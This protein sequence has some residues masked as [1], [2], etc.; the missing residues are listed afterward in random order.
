MSGHSKW[1]KIKRQKG[2]KD[3]KR[4]ALFTKLAKNI[5]LAASE[6]GGDIDMNFSLRLAVE[7]AKQANMPSDN[8]ARAI[9]KGTGEGEKMDIQRISYEA[10]G[11]GGSALIIDC[12]TDNTNR[13]I[14]EVRKTVENAGAKITSVGS[15]GWK[16][17]E[18]GLITIRP[19][20]IVKS[21]KFGAADS[22]EKVDQEEAE[23]EL[24]EIDGISDIAESEMENEEGEVTNVLEI[25]TEKSD[26]ARVLK[27][28]EEL[29]YKVESA[30]LIKS[31]NEKLVLSDEDKTKVE[32]LVENLEELDDVDSVWTDLAY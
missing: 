24:L 28:I 20:K 13:T 27:A 22:L 4:G 17:K 5:T 29:G 2:V 32:K 26:F 14:S 30:E 15:I 6:A 19:A 16:F 23:L 7:K 25:I 12:Q 11:P 1:A 8:I 18:L 3:T 9:K 10:L 21:D 31:A